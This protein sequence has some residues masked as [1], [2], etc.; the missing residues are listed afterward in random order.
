M[1]AWPWPQ[2]RPPSVP[3]EPSAGSPGPLGDV[4]VR[5]VSVGTGE[6]GEEQ[7]GCH[8]HLQHGLICITT[9]T[10]L[11]QEN[12]ARNNKGGGD[13]QAVGFSFPAS[14][15]PT[16]PGV[17][18]SPHSWRREEEV[19]PLLHIRPRLGQTP[20]CSSPLLPWVPSTPVVPLTPPKPPC[21]ACVWEP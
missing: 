13:S 5:C 12:G 4:P 10:L 15:S 2:H 11:D 8:Q 3:P 20:H 19:H 6:A 1:R 14:N 9:D 16:V 7:D 17:R 21:P 18:R